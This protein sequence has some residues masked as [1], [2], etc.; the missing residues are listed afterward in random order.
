[1]F[2]VYYNEIC[3]MPSNTETVNARK[4]HFSIGKVHT[5]QYFAQSKYFYSFAY[6]TMR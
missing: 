3:Q 6:R 2:V 1:M 4:E 5:V